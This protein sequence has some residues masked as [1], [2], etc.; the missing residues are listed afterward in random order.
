MRNV[1]PQVNL[2]FGDGAASVGLFDFVALVQTAH[3]SLLPL[4]KG[5]VRHRKSFPSH[6]SAPR[7]PNGYFHPSSPTSYRPR[8]G[9]LLGPNGTA[10]RPSLPG[11][12]NGPALFPPLPSRIE[13]Q[14]TALPL[15]PPETPT[16]SDVPLMAAPPQARRSKSAGLLNGKEGWGVK[17]L[18]M[19]EMEEKR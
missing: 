17:G 1:K 5:P 2:P 3:S 11:A 10:R 4:K 15:S 9:S 7:P 12:L 13:H 14:P 6:P 18:Q 16:F 8:R 19:A